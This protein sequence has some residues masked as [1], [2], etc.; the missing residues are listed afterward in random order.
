MLF[1]SCHASPGYVLLP[2][3][4]LLSW[5][6]MA[7]ALTLC[8]DL[9]RLC[10][11]ILINTS[12]IKV[13]SIMSFFNIRASFRNFHSLWEKASRKK[14]PMLSSPK[15]YHSLTSKSLLLS[16]CIDTLI[17]NTLKDRF[18]MCLISTSRRPLLLALLLLCRT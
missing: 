2:L 10:F 3:L 18:S 12:F 13:V 8:S 5:T 1:R 15:G 14:V 6:C 7:N 11:A 17:R 4:H 16:D 9:L